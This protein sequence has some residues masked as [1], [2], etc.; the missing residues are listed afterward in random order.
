VPCAEAKFLPLYVKQ[1]ILA[2]DPFETLDVDGVGELIRLAVQRGRTAKP[3]LE[4]GICGEC[5]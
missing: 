3:D 4:L 2:A 5:G 1:G